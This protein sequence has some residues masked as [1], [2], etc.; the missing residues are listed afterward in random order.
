MEKTARKNIKYF[1]SYS[2]KCKISPFCSSWFQHVK[3]VSWICEIYYDGKL[4][5]S[6]LNIAKSTVLE[7]SISQGLTCQHYI[8]L[9]GVKFLPVILAVGWSIYQLT[10]LIYYR[11][12]RPAFLIITTLAELQTDNV[13]STCFWGVV[14]SPCLVITMSLQLDSSY[15][16]MTVI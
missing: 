12:V 15:W 1:R 13:K 4:V 2:N 11:H 8:Y 16:V 6:C 3:Q 9:A 10:H 14:T 5:L 7:F